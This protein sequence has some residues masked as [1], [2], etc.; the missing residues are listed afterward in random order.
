VR[1]RRNARGE[2]QQRRER[3]EQRLA[4][5]RE[6]LCEETAAR[7]HWEEA[8]RVLQKLTDEEKRRKKAESGRKEDSP[9][10][11]CRF[12][13]AL[14]EEE[15]LAKQDDQ[16]CF[17]FCSGA[18]VQRVLTHIAEVD[19]VMS[20]AT[21]E[22]LRN[23]QVEKQRAWALYWELIALTVMEIVIGNNDMSVWD[24]SLFL[25]YAFCFFEI[26]DIARDNCR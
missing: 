11:D 20:T 4:V 7:H 24:R 10:I 21:G 25:T 18:T 12:P 22:D 26:Y 17:R 1:Q 23:L 2:E 8:R 13:A 19:A 14:I 9:L 5:L 16:I 15:R 3:V 6:K